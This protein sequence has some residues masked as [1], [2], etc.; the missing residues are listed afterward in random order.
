MNAE[1]KVLVQESFAKVLPISETAAD[2]FYNRLFELDPSLR[3]LFKGDMKDQGRKLM[4]MINVAVKGLDDLDKIVPAVQ[5]L[6]QRHGGYGVKDKD[7]DTVATALLWTLEQGLGKDFTPEVK[8]AWVEVYLLLSG[9]MKD[10][11]AKA[12]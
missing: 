8:A 2:L 11:S 6:G 7:Y 3:P 9:V 4:D 12:M 1:Q 5:A 10:A